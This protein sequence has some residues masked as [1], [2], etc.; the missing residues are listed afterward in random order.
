[1]AV[2]NQQRAIALEAAAGEP[3]RMASVNYTNLLIELGRADDALAFGVPLLERLQ[4]TRHSWG[5]DGVQANLAAA[6][7]AQGRAPQARALAHA[8]WAQ[9]ALVESQPTWADH[10]AWLA[11]LEGRPRDAA[12]L[13]GHADAL[14]AVR[15]HTR[16]GVE[17]QSY[18]QAV[19]LATAALGSAEVE[20]LRAE[21]AALDDDAAERVAFADASL[22]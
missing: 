16:Q 4:S 20:R 9:R 21:G 2:R 17:L 18:A 11:G 13:L 6:W 14:Y 3:Y 8:A 12:R 5:L 7:L 1:E 15:R 10:L 19:A 22:G